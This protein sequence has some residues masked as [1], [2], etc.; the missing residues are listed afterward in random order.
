MK[1]LHQRMLGALLVATVGGLATS[2]AQAQQL[3]WS[4]GVASP[5]VQLA[6]GYA[7]MVAQQPVYQPAY[8]PVYQMGYPVTYPATYPITYPAAYP[9]VVS[10]RY[11]AGLYRCA[12]SWWRHQFSCNPAG[13]MATSGNI[14][15][16][17]VGTT[18]MATPATIDRSVARF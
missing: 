10:S 8:Y 1:S 17:V 16:T 12:R 5:G 11:I 13:S 7:P 9:V 4:I 14:T 3:N 18:S 2:T 6:V 15:N